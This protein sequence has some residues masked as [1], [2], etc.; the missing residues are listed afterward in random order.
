MVAAR[1]DF[2]NVRVWRF[3]GHV[4][5]MAQIRSGTNPSKGARRTQAGRHIQRSPLPTFRTAGRTAAKL[6]ERFR[7]PMDIDP[8]AR[9]TNCNAGSSGEHPFSAANAKSLR[10]RSGVRSRAAKNSSTEELFSLGRYGQL[11]LVEKG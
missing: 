8:P 10:I 3:L 6:A 2:Q 1:C 11:A 5:N 7:V 9:P 4:A